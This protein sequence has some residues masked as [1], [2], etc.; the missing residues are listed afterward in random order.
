MRML[1]LNIHEVF[2]D[3]M[4]LLQGSSATIDKT[5][6]T[7]TGIHQPAQQAYSA[8]VIMIFESVF[9]QPFRE[10]RQSAEYRTPR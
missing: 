6:G 7:S 9:A 4:Q 1:A 3:R 8:I 2:T 5:A 10:L